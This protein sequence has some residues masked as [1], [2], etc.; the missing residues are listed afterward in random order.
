MHDVDVEVDLLA[1][2]LRHAPFMQMVVAHW[3]PVHDVEVVVDVERFLPKPKLE[4]AVTML[5]QATTHKNF[6]F[7][8]SLPLNNVLIEIT[9]LIYHKTFLFV[10]IL[11]LI[12]KIMASHVCRYPTTEASCLFSALLASPFTAL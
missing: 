12:S 2:S 5:I 11:N 8:I 7:I 9:L 1:S 4:V 3:S 6:L 10:N